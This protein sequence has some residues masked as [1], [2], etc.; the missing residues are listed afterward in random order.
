MAREK[1]AYLYL[2]LRTY[3]PDQCDIRVETHT[4]CLITT[5][6]IRDRSASYTFFVRIAILVNCPCFSIICIGS[7][8]GLTRALITNSTTRTVT[9]TGPCSD[10]FTTIVPTS[11]VIAYYYI[12]FGCDEESTLH[13]ATDQWKTIE[14]RTMRSHAICPAVSTVARWDENNHRPSKDLTPYLQPQSDIHGLS[15]RLFNINGN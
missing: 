8:H 3:Q 6:M 11:E 1:V 7:I 4:C 10:A 2:Y 13:V 9:V 5:C 15:T 14:S 12:L